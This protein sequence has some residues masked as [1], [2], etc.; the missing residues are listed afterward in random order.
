MLK[1]LNGTPLPNWVKLLALG[2]SVGVIAG[3]NHNMMDGLVKSQDKTTAA[4]EELR[5]EIRD[6]SAT[7]NEMFLL[8]QQLETLSHRIDALEIKRGY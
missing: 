2:A 8:S 3:V 5:V 7:K 1:L 6:K 4:L